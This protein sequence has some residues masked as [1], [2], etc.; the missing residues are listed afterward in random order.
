MSFTALGACTASGDE[1]TPPSDQFFFPTGLAVSPDGSKLFV[2]NANS[3]LRWDSGSVQVVDLDIVD[4]ITANW[5]DLGMYPTD[6]NPDPDRTETLTCDEAMFIRQGAGVRIGNFATDIAVQDMNDGS[7]RLIVP[8]RG[9]PSIAWIDY[10]NDALSCSKSTE[11][12]ALCDDAHR[13]S[14]VLNNAALSSLPEEPF[15]AYADSNGQFAVVTH[16]TTGSVTLIDSRPGV[17]AQVTDIVGGVF[18]ADPSTGLRG[19]TGVA[20]RSNGADG[21]I[22]YVGSRSEDRI[23][24]FTV[25]RP[26]N[27]APPFLLAGNY[28]F[29]DGV[30]NNS[31]GSTDT[32]GMAFSPSGERMYL[33][34]RRPP[35]LQVI[36]TSLDE[37]G[38]PRN[39]FVGNTDICRQASTLALID[40]GAGERAYMTCF[41]DGDIY[42]VDPTGVPHVE[43]VVTVGRGPYTIT[44]A[45][46]R[47]KLFVSNF[48]ED[49]IAVIDARPNVPTHD[50]VVLRLGAVR[51]P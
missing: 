6:C 17:D 30:G 34:N 26:V 29:L 13:L 21:S 11:S 33:V 15:A 27:D 32:R 36:D 41:Q 50:R 48:L 38:F 28:F 25:G 51:A 40:A 44:A 31:G 5:V 16:L 24:T 49:T 39:K 22:V 20:G 7:L 3:E 14:Y 23:Q 1:V 19:A 46:S 35:S 2:A 10:A 37:G 18:A 42:V 4:Q 43:N 12:N 9:D 47:K 45:P 8:T